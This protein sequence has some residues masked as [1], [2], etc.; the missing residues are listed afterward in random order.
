MTIERSETIKE[1]AT[2]LAKAQGAL[3]PAAKDAE[4]PHFKSKYADLSA[5]WEACRGPLA[6][7]G[8]SVI[9]LPADSEPGRMALTSMLLHA[10]G[11]YISATYSI[12][13]M[14]DTAHGAGSALTYLRRYALAALVGIVADEDDDGNGASQPPQQQ[15]RPQPGRSQPARPTTAQAPNGAGKKPATRDGMIARIADLTAEADTLKLTIA[16]KKPPDEMTDQEL[17]A[18]GQALSAQIAKAR[19]QAQAKA[20]TEADEILP[21]KAP[22]ERPKYNGMPRAELPL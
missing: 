10:S 2:A 17:I 19:S 11:E 9:Q 15:T 20:Q 6:S 7:N 13:L 8:L 16:L 21:E 14:Q 3:R 4:N 22:A 1:L 12:K 5:V 18:H